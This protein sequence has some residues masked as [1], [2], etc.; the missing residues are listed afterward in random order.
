MNQEKISLLLTMN[1]SHQQIDIIP[2]FHSS[3][4]FSVVITVFALFVLRLGIQTFN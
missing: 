3:R 4:L 2:S 1:T